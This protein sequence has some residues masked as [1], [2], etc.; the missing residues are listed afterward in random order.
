MP[1]YYYKDSE[2]PDDGYYNDGDYGYKSDRAESIYS[3]PDPTT[4]EPN[5]CENHKDALGEYEY[6]HREPE[7]KGY[8]LE[9]LEC[10]GDKIQR[11]EECVDDDNGTGA[12]WEVGHEGEIEGYKYGELKYKGDRI[13]EQEELK[14]EEAY[15]IEGRTCQSEEN[16]Y[17]HWES[18]YH[19]DR[20]YEPQ[21]H[22]DD[23]AGEHTPHPPFP[24]HT[25][26]Q[27]TRYPTRINKVT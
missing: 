24:L 18:K 10:E 15:R 17:R 22:N 13:H 6:E 7:Y 20:A 9:E 19:Q 12:D 3:D 1:L 11:F 8:K 4:S 23:E 2:Y 5:H 16:A 26:P 21:E 27:P 25:R 14:R